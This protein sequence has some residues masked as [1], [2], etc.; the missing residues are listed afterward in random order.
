MDLAGRL[1]LDGYLQ[2]RLAIASDELQAHAVHAEV[3]GRAIGIIGWKDEQRRR[4]PLGIRK[5]KV[6]LAGSS[7]RIVSSLRRQSRLY[8][9]ASP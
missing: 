6:A 8:E 9:P 4:R 3:G 5:G 1:V 2:P 7:R